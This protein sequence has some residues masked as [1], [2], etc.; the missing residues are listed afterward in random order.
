MHKSIRA[1]DFSHQE[2]NVAMSEYM[3]GSCYQDL[4]TSILKE[5]GGDFL[6][7]VVEKILTIL[8]QKFSIHNI[9]T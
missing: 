9:V 5:Y 6:T 1:I 8:A 4:I 2:R 3:Q 7:N